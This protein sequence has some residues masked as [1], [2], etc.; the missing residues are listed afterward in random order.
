MCGRNGD[1]GRGWRAA[2]KRR[3]K[4]DGFFFRTLSDETER[5][6]ST[7]ATIT[8][9]FEEKIKKLNDEK[10]DRVSRGCEL[11]VARCDL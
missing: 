4:K 6:K 2:R 8:D 5:R 7:L 9:S 3:A 10:L 1:G 11:G